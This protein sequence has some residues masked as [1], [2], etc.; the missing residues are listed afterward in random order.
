MISSGYLALSL[1]FSNFI[2]FF[3]TIPGVNFATRNETII[4]TTQRMYLAT[5]ICRSIKLYTGKEQRVW[6]KFRIPLLIYHPSVPRKCIRECMESLPF[7]LLSYSGGDHSPPC[8]LYEYD[9]SSLAHICPF[10]HEHLNKQTLIKLP[11]IHSSPPHRCKLRSEIHNP[12][13]WR[14]KSMLKV[15]NVKS[16][17][18][19]ITVPP[20]VAWHLNVPM[21]DCQRHLP[22]SVT[23]LYE[24]GNAH[25]CPLLSILCSWAMCPW[26]YILILSLWVRSKWK[27]FWWAGDGFQAT[28][29]TQ[30]PH[31]S[32]KWP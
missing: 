25:L 17:A 24:G 1:Q 9:N 30:S 22:N 8:W 23:S 4:T 26:A 19:H 18:W 13:S 7:I 12:S 2:P 32:A 31:S 10:T 29:L 28:S 15:Q 27:D 5:S 3:F 6:D 14:K 16:E 20:F 11:L 21:H